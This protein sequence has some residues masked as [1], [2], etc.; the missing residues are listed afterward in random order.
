MGLV[1]WIRQFENAEISFTAKTSSINTGNEGRDRHLKS[2]DFFDME[3][4]PNISFK[5]RS[6]NGDKLTGDLSI[7]DVTKEVIFDVEFNGVAVDPYGQTKAGFEVSGA[8]NGKDYNLNWNVVMEAGNIVVS[9]QV[10]LLANLQ[11]I[12]QLSRH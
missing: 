9:D 3:N 7:R 12:K 8:I 1:E 6:F 2:A 5:S 10:K 11:F 4:Y